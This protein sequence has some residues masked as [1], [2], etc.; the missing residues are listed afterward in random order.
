[1]IKNKLNGKIY[2]GQTIC[3]KVSKRWCDHKSRPKGCLKGAFTLHGI[4]NFEFSTICEIPEGPGWREELDSREILEISTRNTIAPNGYNIETGGN[5]RKTVNIET[6]M[7][8]SESR[9]GSAHPLF[10][11]KYTD[12]EKKHLSE[13]NK[14]K[15]Q[16]TVTI[17]KKFKKI[18]KYTIDGDY[19]KT[20]ESM[21]EV[22]SEG[23][24][25][26]SVSKC[27]NGKLKTAGGFV[28]KFSL[29]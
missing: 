23:V 26:S 15:P 22:K 12:D 5:R 11:K 2:I 14:G 16:T 27:C 21:K 9:K 29:L 25:P 20:Y 19:I 1:M 18:D 24:P 3:E 10:G 17:S 4:H 13:M 7:K 8:I 28:W 6:R